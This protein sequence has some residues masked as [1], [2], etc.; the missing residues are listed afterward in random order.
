MKPAS[1][2]EAIK[3]FAR[4]RLGCDCPE[5]VFDSILVSES[6]TTSIPGARYRK[7]VIGG[8]LLIY[9]VSL[10][11]DPSISSLIEKLIILGRN[12]RDKKNYNRFRLVLV[13]DEHDT[14]PKSNGQDQT[15][16]KTHL[17]LIKKEDIPQ[18]LIPRET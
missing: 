6:L 14:A 12:E 8:R 4:N 3:T 1:P 17:H 16:E 15:D 13:T 7:I 5:N 2:P 9:I 18:T 11:K 10:S